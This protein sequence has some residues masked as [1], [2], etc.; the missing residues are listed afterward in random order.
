[1]ALMYWP[2]PLWR[3]KTRVRSNKPCRPS[4][5]SPDCPAYSRTK[6]CGMQITQ[7]K[8]TEFGPDS[9]IP[10]KALRK[11]DAVLEVKLTLSPI[12]N[13]TSPDP[14]LYRDVVA[15]WYIR[16]GKAYAQNGWAQRIQYQ[17]TPLDWMNC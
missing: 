9:G 3:L 16:S 11:G 13:L 8:F 12:L 6:A 17:P 14:A 5:L 10:Q 1:M 2:G 15:R 7:S 4:P